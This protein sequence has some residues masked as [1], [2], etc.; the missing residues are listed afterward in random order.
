VPAAG[1][2]LA[3]TIALR[4]PA[5]RTRLAAAARETPRR[6]LASLVLV[7]GLIAIWMLEAPTTDALSEQA[8]GLNGTWTLNDT[9]AILSGRTPLV[10]FHPIYAKLLPYPTAVVLAAFGA[11]TLVY[12]TFMAL[13][14]ALTLLAVWAVFR[15]VARSSLAALALFVPFIAMTDVEGVKDVSV[16][17]MPPMWPMRFGGAYLLA[18]L[19]VRQLAG[20]RPRSAWALAFVAGLLIVNCPEFGVAAALASAAAWLCARPPDSPPAAGRLVAS[21]AGGL[22]SAA[23][24]VAVATFARAGELPRLDV[25]L[26]WPRIFGRLGLL[27]MPLQ[28]V[29]LHLAIYATFVA[30]IAVAA[31]RLAQR[32]SDRVLTGM[33]MWAGTFGLLVGSYYVGRP[34]IAKLIAML[35]PWSFALSMLAVAALAGLARRDWRTTAPRLLVLFGLAA[36]IFTLGDFPWPHGQVSRLGRRGSAPLYMTQAKQFVSRYAQR[37]ENLAILLPMSYRISYELRLQNVAPY[38]YMN[39]IVTRRQMATLLDT[40]RSE[41]VA[42]VFTPEPESFLTSEGDAAPE[43]LEALAAAGYHPV[44]TQ[45]GMIALRRDE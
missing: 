15:T 32:E 18:W 1:L 19:T 33:L 12:T 23:A 24:L 37:D 14:T 35:S 34:D 10:D 2:L 5:M 29:G 36:S 31:V 41:R 20:R 17:A 39:A 42:A 3:A 11:N 25:L 4:R 21:A 9:M 27:S 22:L 8:V 7:I 13:L 16:L 38:G 30:C 44:G 45:D 28:V 40:L 43:Q 26:E 6:H